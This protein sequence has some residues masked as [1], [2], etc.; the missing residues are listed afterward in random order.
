MLKSLAL[1]VLAVSAACALSACGGVTEGANG[2]SVT[3]DGS[4][5]TK[6]VAVKSCKPGAYGALD[7]A[8]TIKN[9][10]AAKATYTVTVEALDAKGARL[11]EAN[12]AANAVAA[13]GTATATL[14][15][16]IDGGAKIASCKVAQ[17]TRI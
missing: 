2:Q 16:T 11:A 4:D 5:A 7:V 15:G 9:S 1:A 6:D 17:V 14:A 8:V 3:V 12:G 10:T 13:K